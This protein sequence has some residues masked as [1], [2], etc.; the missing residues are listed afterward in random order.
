MARTAEDESIA[1]FFHEEAADS[2]ELTI[3]MLSPRLTD[4]SLMTPIQ[5]PS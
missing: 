4:D 2:E 3:M 5:T 1:V